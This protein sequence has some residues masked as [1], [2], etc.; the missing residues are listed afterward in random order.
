MYLSPPPSRGGGFLTEAEE[1]DLTAFFSTIRPTHQTG[2]R[3][4]KFVAAGLT[5]LHIGA[6]SAFAQATTAP[7]EH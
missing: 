3:M 4:V 1:L 7:I 6:R 2:R 5:M